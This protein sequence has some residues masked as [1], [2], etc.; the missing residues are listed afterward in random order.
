MEGE[1]GE[2]E[3][4]FPGT[5][6]KVISSEEGLFYKVRWDEHAADD[7]SETEGFTAEDIRVPTA[8]AAPKAEP[9]AVG[10]GEISKVAAEQAVERPAECP[11]EQNAEQPAQQRAELETV[12]QVE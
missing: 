3:D 1:D 10:S 5:I 8:A 12:R 9:R 7:E 6:S 4:W 11:A 2:P